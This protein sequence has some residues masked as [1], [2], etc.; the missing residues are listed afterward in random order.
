MPSGGKSQPGI[1]HDTEQVFP[2]WRKPR[3][4]RHAHPVQP[5]PEVFTVHSD[6][7]ALALLPFFAASQTIWQKPGAGSPTSWPL[8]SS[9]WD[10][11]VPK[12]QDCASLVVS[13]TLAGQLG[14][15]SQST[16]VSPK[17]S[18]MVLVAVNPECPHNAEGVSRLVMRLQSSSNCTASAPEVWHGKEIFSMVWA[19]AGVHNAKGVQ[20][21]GSQV[22]EEHW[23]T[24]YCPRPLS[25]CSETF[26][27]LPGAVGQRRPSPTSQTH[28]PK[29]KM[30]GTAMP[31]SGTKLHVSSPG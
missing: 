4:S 21:P 3:S 29:G 2:S 26:A 28:L 9:L 12:Q 7:F 17:A 31:S 19:S 6:G 23:E 10:Q 13:N 25:R 30:N 16:G 24:S 14:P 20:L 15:S 8:V 27:H 22:R 18:K 5:G 11:S 1:S